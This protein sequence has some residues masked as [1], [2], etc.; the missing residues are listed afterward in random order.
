M[1]NLLC[2]DEVIKKKIASMG[3]SVTAVPQFTCSGALGELNWK[4]AIAVPQ[5][6]C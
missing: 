6:G 2:K 3:D 1:N 5:R 4:D